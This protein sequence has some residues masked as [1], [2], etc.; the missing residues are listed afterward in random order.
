MTE[1]T[2]TAYIPPSPQPQAPAP[3][4][5]Q[6]KPPTKACANGDCK[7]CLKGGL[8]LPKELTSFFLILTLIALTIGGILFINTKREMLELERALDTQGPEVTT[9]VAPPEYPKP[10]PKVFTKT[11][12]LPRPTT[13]GGLGVQA[14]I[15]QRRT[16]RVFSADP[17][18]L[19]EL[20]QIVW[21]AQ[22]ISDPTTG[23]RTAP[24]ARE[25]YP[26]TIY[27]VAKNV[28]GLEPGLYAY[29]PQE[30]ALGK[31]ALANVAEVLATSGV[32][33]GALEAPVVFIPAA[34]LA[35]SAEKMGA[36]AVTSTMLEGGH[37][38]QNMYLQAESLQM[39]LVVMAGFSPEKLQ[40]A[41]QLDPADT[42][43]YV[44]PFGHRGVEVP[45]AE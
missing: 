39:G 41:L 2:P 11:V 1:N 5:T 45:E 34:S 16:R 7:E 12:V 38:G 31:L 33:P 10:Q 19:A 4:M 6:T 26:Y 22:G 42:P 44:I 40:T 8:P 9:E 24:S 37:I 27:V 23:H 18:T 43:V 15:Q 13:V 17:V 30:H 36:S 20:G 14:A 28:A 29:M 3:L 25:A 21:S 35:V 32:Q